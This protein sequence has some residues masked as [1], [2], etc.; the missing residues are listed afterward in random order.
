MQAFLLGTA[1]D[2]RGFALAGVAGRVC[3]TAAEVEEA[4]AHVKARTDLAL[5]LVS[6][7]VAK[8]AWPALEQVEASPP[9]LVVLP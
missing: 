9:A 4:C 6:G 5:V 3:A 8:L 1:D 2:V 7:E